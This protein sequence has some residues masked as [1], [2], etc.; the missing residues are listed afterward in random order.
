MHA[1]MC[2]ELRCG[3]TAMTE[4]P[5]VTLWIGSGQRRPIVRI[6]YPFTHHYRL[7]LDLQMLSCA[8]EAT[9][10]SCIVPVHVAWSGSLDAPRVTGLALS[11]H[12]SDSS[13]P[14]ALGHCRTGISHQPT[15][16]N[17]KEVNS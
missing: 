16:T 14:Y 11:R 9:M 5:S 7:K 6:S 17:R 1:E 3:S 2:P 12:S 4:K 15:E 8:E 10:S 13:T